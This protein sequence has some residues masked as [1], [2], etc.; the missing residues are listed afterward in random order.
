[1]R[2]GVEYWK[3]SS[4]GFCIATDGLLGNFTLFEGHIIAMSIWL[5]VPDMRTEYSTK[6]V[7]PVLGC[8]M[9]FERP[10][11]FAVHTIDAVHSDRALYSAP[12]ENLG[13]LSGRHLAKLRLMK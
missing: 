6:C 12:C 5:V 7:W 13:V 11:Q 8:E 3:R 10:G 9:R 2:L 1:M 4:G